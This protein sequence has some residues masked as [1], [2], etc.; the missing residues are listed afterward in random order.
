MNTWTLR[1]A[2]FLV[3]YLLAYNSWSQPARFLSASP[4]TVTDRGAHHRSWDSIKTYRTSYGRDI[5]RT[6]SYVELGTGLHYWENGQWK[7]TSTEIQILEGE[8][9]ASQGPIKVSFAANLN[10]IGAIDMLTSQGRRF[11]SHVLCLAYTDAKSGQS[12]LIGQ[13]QDSNGGV[14][15][16]NEVIYQDAFD[17]DVVADVRYNYSPAGLEQDIVLLAAPPSPSEWGLDPSSTRLEVW[18]E[19]V[20]APTPNQTLIVLREEAPPGARNAW[21]EPDLA[22]HQ[23]D[24][25]EIDIGAG[26]AFTSGDRDVF[27]GGALTAKLWTQVEGR[28][29]LIEQVPYSDLIPLLQTLPPMVRNAKQPGRNQERALAQAARTLPRRPEGESGVWAANQFAQGVSTRSGVVLDYTATIGSLTNFTFKGDTTYFV[30]SPVNLYGTTTVEGGAVIKY[31]NNPCSLTFNGP[32]LCKTSQWHPAV[33]TAMDED[34]VGEIIAGSLG[35]PSGTYGLYTLACKDTSAPYPWKHIQIR[36]ANYGFALYS[37][38]SVDVRHAQIGYC[39]RGLTS[40]AGNNHFRNVL[41]HDATHAI[42]NVS[43]STNHFENATFHSIDNL[44]FSTNNAHPRMTN[45]LIITVADKVVYQGGA[46]VVES[47]SDSGVFQTAGSGEHYLANGSVYVDAG[48]TNIDAELLAD[49]SRYTT[50]P[51]AILTSFIDSST[52]LGRSALRDTDTPDLGYHYPPIDYIAS[53]LTVSNASLLVTNAA[54][55]GIAF[56]GTNYGINLDSGASLV[57]QG[58]GDD[59]NRFVR[60]HA[61]QE[62]PSESGDGYAL[63]TSVYNASTPPNALFRFTDFPLM[64]Q[65]YLLNEENE[66]GN[67]ENLK[68]QDSQLSSGIL[69]YSGHLSNLVVTL[70]NSLLDRMDI[71]FQVYAPFSL[72]SYNNLFHKGSLAFNHD[73]PDSDYFFYDNLFDESYIYQNANVVISNNY[74]A[75]IVTNAIFLEPT[76]GVVWKLLSGSPTY[77][78]GPLGRFYY[79][80]DDGLASTNIDAGSR[81]ATNAKLYH[82]TTTT[83]QVRETNTLVD[84]GFHYLA[85]D[86]EGQALDED[87]DG[88]PD[89]LEDLNGN[90][91]YDAASGETDWQEYDSLFEISTGPSLET[92]TPLKP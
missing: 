56:N 31:T 45:T 62:A 69:F 9:I 70:T 67:F 82:F 12:V 57:S 65:S 19:F 71:D 83:N 40:I 33:F 39:N 74:N 27:S 75:Y 91:S 1:S 15:P 8:A 2:G 44:V 35:T 87:E 24:F 80:T 54:T 13:I 81:Y 61:I 23:L 6:N 68:F 72:L 7:P 10:S 38:V 49:L 3:L 16:P 4:V 41:I 11:R 17:G 66:R 85:V 18:T 28:T 34:S 5:Y 63:L 90:G 14:L 42:W 37:G 43:N 47:L 92:Y 52:F 21:A 29:F 53:S 79:A 55:I 78:N 89:Y 36:H 84:I 58:F 76:N 30:G 59:L 22:D 25:G 77:L 46:D 73:P 64:S 88:I 20:A 32:V 26:Y 48:T 50:E 51:P 86:V 60:L